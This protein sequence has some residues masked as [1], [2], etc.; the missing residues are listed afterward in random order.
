[1]PKGLAAVGVRLGM[2]GAAL[3]AV[4][5]SA[6]RGVAGQADSVLYATVCGRLATMEIAGPACNLRRHGADRYNRAW[7]DRDHRDAGAGRDRGLEGRS[8]H[9]A[10][11]F[12][13]S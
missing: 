6:R 11:A 13:R 1:M 9:D 7:K 8:G 3:V 5:N 10:P 2:A 4:R 12:P